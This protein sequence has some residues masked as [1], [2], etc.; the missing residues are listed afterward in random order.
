MDPA[1]AGHFTTLQ[2][3]GGRVQGRDLHLVRLVT[4][5]RSA[6][7]S[8]PQ[9]SV[10]LKRIR[11][12]MRAAGPAAREC[13][14]RIRIHP[15]RPGYRGDHLGPGEHDPAFAIEVD[16]EPPRHP[17]AAPLRLQT[18]VGGRA[19][20]GIKHLALD[21]QLQARQAARDAGCDDALLVAED[22]RLIE[23]TFWNIAFWDGAAVVWPD[24]PALPGVTQ[25]LLRRELE[26]AG[27]VQ[28]RER[29]GVDSL[30]GLRAAFTLNSTGIADIASIDGHGLPGDPAAGA[31]LRRLL[32]AVPWDDF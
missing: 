1:D 11:D 4:A 5:S 29:L 3:R 27:V 21:H 23:G 6:Y 9:K 31:L 10:I 16:F 28:R 13:T 19:L 30:A 17:P 26:R 8:G 22:G 24:A 32:E 25:F 15:P 14:L 2:V 7:G 12:E 20:P 18:H